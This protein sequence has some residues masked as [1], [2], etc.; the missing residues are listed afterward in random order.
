[1]RLWLLCEVLLLLCLCTA[2]CTA[3]GGQTL[4]IRRPHQP[5]K[6]DRTAHTK[7]HALGQRLARR[8]LWPSRPPFN[9]KPAIAPRKLAHRNTFCRPNSC[10]SVNG[11]NDT[12]PTSRGS[13]QVFLPKHGKWLCT[14]TS[15]TAALLLYTT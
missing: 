9:P 14:L 10:R 4:A 6:V 2:P 8:N 7:H 13:V 15:I 5:R 11:I 3:V 1:M 12:T